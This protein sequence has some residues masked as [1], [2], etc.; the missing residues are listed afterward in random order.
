MH[1]SQDHIRRIFT[2]DQAEEVWDSEIMVP[3]DITGWYEKH[4][5]PEQRGVGDQTNF[6]TGT[7]GE[8]IMI[9][10]AYSPYPLSGATEEFYNDPN[11]PKQSLW[12]SPETM[13]AIGVPYTFVARHGIPVELMNPALI[14]KHPQGTFY[15]LTG[16]ILK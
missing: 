1:I 3:I 6:R 5:G 7:M 15:T 8:A 13:K 9:V 12:F 2:A 10:Q 16:E 4:G 11:F 14:S